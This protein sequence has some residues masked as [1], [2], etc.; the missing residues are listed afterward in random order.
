M[1]NQIADKRNHL[2]LEVLQLINEEETIKQ[3]YHYFATPSEL[4]VDNDHQQLPVSQKEME[5]DMM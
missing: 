1:G 5:I 4:I 2:F 3:E